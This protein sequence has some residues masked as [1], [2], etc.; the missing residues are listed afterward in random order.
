VSLI[1]PQ[2]A[3]RLIGDGT[4]GLVPAGLV[5]AGIVVYGD[6]AARRL[7]APAELP[8]GLVTAVIGAP[9]LLWLLARANR[10]GTGG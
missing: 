6:L 5:G 7:F 8:V 1:A 10:I 3:R 2:I 9:V 4:L